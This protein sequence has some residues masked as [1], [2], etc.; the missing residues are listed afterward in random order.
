MEG[1]EIDQFVSLYRCAVEHRE[2]GVV[3]LYQGAG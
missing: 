2:Q 1:D 3:L